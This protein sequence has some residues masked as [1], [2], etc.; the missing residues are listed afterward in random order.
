MCSSY[1]CDNYTILSKIELLITYPD[2]FSIFSRNCP[3]YFSRFTM[4]TIIFYNFFNPYYIR[5]RASFICQTKCNHKHLALK[6]GL[7]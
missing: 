2:S 4:Y 6:E 1:F 3:Q 7:L 5:S